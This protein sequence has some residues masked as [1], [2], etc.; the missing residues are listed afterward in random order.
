[1]KRIAKAIAVF[2]TLTLCITLAA[3]ATAYAASKPAK[4]TNVKQS[5]ATTTAIKLTYKKASGAKSYQVQYSTK[6]SMKS[7]KAVKSTGTSATIKGLK[8]NTTYYAR[9][10]A[11]NAKKQYGA[12]S[13]KIKI[14]TNPAKPAKVTGV[15]A[16]ASGNTITVTY[17]KAKNATY[18]QI[19]YTAANASKSA[20]ATSKSASATL[21][22]LGSGVKYK[23]RVRACNK[24]ANGK[25]QVGAWSSVTTVT[26]AKSHTHTW[27]TKTVVDQEAYTTYDSEYSDTYIETGEVQADG[28]WRT[29]VITYEEY[30][31]RCAAQQMAFM[32]YL[33]DGGD[34]DDY[35]W[36]GSVLGNFWDHFELI[37]IEHPAVTHTETVCSVCGAK[38]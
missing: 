30:E 7:A 38:K 5:S 9:V 20:V 36:T 31:K 24:L 18:Y 1:M 11:C 28:T 22:N 8:A 35:D 12:W 29:I 2:M 17:A 27:V 32:Q 10:R 34:Q 14:K 13:G 16:K 26:T 4:V 33:A 23:I 37:T 25:Q 15:K 21:K 6:S 19:E 3:P